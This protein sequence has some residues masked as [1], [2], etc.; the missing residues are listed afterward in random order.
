MFKIRSTK[1]GGIVLDQSYTYNT[2]GE[3]STIPVTRKILSWITDNFME[4]DFTAGEVV[5][6]CGV[7]RTSVIAAIQAGQSQGLIHLVRK[8]G[9]KHVYSLTPNVSASEQ[10]EQGENTLP[11]DEP[12]ARERYLI[13][14]AP[15]P[16]A[17]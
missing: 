6:G 13:P 7:G 15:T 9:N 4:K 1:E 12:E 17:G 14:S 8:E 10:S 11:P 3:Y 2:E 16:Y 5:D